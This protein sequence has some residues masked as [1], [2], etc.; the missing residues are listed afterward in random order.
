[1]WLILPS[2]GQQNEEWNCDEAHHRELQTT[3]RDLGALLY[4]RRKSTSR[5][6]TSWSA[7]IEAESCFF[8]RGQTAAG[9][10]DSASVDL[11]RRSR[12]AFPSFSVDERPTA[13]R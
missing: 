12:G 1:M 13:R 6:N 4:A 2:S 5:W 8:I 11:R 9:I 7:A 10:G 3:H